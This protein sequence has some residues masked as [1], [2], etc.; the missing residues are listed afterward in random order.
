MDWVKSLT[1][2]G[3]GL[4]L[5]GSTLLFFYGLP[6][7][8]VGDMVLWGPLAMNPSGMREADWQ[9]IADR[10]QKR[11]TFLN[12]VGFGLVAGGTALQIAGV[13]QT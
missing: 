3:L 7:R 4:T 6:L 13:L 11:T 1:L 5:M 10:F 12:R 8:K 2:V 9:R